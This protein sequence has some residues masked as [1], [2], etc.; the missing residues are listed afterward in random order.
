MFQD[1]I[2]ISMLRAGRGNHLG[3]GDRSACEL[4]IRPEGGLTGHRSDR[5]HL[6]VLWASCPTGRWQHECRGGINA[7]EVCR[8]RWEQLCESPVCALKYCRRVEGTES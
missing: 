6:P 2:D 7:A 5:G 8:H 1:N 3:R 4:A